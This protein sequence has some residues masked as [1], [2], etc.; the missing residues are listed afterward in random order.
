M[1]GEHTSW[2]DIASNI[3]RLFVDARCPACFNPRMTTPEIK[4]TKRGPKPG[5]TKLGAAVR[6]MLRN[7]VKVKTIAEA[8]GCTE[9]LVRY[10]RRMMR[11]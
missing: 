6:E 3:F 7:G 8:L 9:H 1:Q 11:R 5:T 2:R 10:H 4:M